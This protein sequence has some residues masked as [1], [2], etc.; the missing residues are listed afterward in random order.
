[1]KERILGNLTIVVLIFGGLFI[2]SKLAGPIPFSVNSTTTTKS[3]AFSVVGEGKVS[4]KPDM[5]AVTVGIITKASTVKSGQDQSNQVINNISAAVKNLGVG[6]EDI[7]TTN[8]NINPDYDYSGGT[9]RITGYTA[10][11]NLAIKVREIDKVNEVIDKAT[12]NG[13]NE[14]Y[15]LSFEVEDKTAAQNEARQLAV[16]EAKKKAQEAARIAGFSL[17]KIINYQ[18]N[19]S[20]PPIFYGGVQ[21]LEKAQGAPQTQVEPGS[22]EV[23][24]SVTLSYEVR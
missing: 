12:A 11:A 17:G 1:M 24:V 16:E 13:A 7:K 10:T 9:S 6:E 3:D 22:N 23:T 19:L 15:G 20:G 18:E 8:Y 2:Y 4:V 5:A 14:V 21:A